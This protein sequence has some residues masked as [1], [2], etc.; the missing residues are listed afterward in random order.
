MIDD[1][2]EDEDA[3]DVRRGNWTTIGG[4]RV[5]WNVVHEATGR[6][7]THVGKE[8]LVHKKGFDTIGALLHGSVKKHGFAERIGTSMVLEL[9]ADELKE[10]IPAEMHARFR[11]LHIQHGILTV[12]CLSSGV[13]F[14]IR[15]HERELLD[16][17]REA[18][19][20]VE[21]LRTILSTW[22]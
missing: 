17:L 3:E 21:S 8:R 16:A 15:K 12:A 4:K 19:A 13:A 10:R 6:N 22:R 18:G 5:A 1:E 11:P 7:R 2:N 14:T 20:H 9:F